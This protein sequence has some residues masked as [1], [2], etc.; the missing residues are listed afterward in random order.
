M[1]LATSEIGASSFATAD[2]YA[3][4]SRSARSEYQA[5]SHSLGFVSLVWCERRASSS[6]PFRPSSSAPSEYDAVFTCARRQLKAE[7]SQPTD[8]APKTLAS[9]SV[10]PEPTNGS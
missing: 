10:V 5:H 1:T 7:M 2:L 8:A 6:A 3:R 9:T 4:S